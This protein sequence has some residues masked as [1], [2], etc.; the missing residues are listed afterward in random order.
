ML[1]LDEPTGRAPQRE[2][3]ERWWLVG[4]AAALLAVV[5]SLVVWAEEDPPSNVDEPTTTTPAVPPITDVDTDQADDSEGASG[6]AEIARDFLIAIS[7]HDAGAAWRSVAPNAA[8]SIATPFNPTEVVERGITLRDQLAWLEAWDWRWDDPS[9]SAEVH[10]VRGFVIS[11]DTTIQYDTTVTCTAEARYRLSDVDG[12]SQDAGLRLYAL[13]DRIVYGVETSLDDGQLIWTPS[14]SSFVDWAETN[15]AEESANIWTDD[16]P[17]L[18]QQA[19]SIVEELVREYVDTASSLVDASA[20]VTPP[21]AEFVGAVSAHDADTAAALVAD[22]AG[23][24]EVAPGS[25]LNDGTSAALS[26]QLRWLEA[27]GWTWEDVACTD[28]A[29]A[30]D[31]VFC[32]FD[33]RNRLTEATETE[34]PSWATFIVADGRIRSVTVDDDKDNYSG[35]AFMPY[36]SWVRS[37]YPD[38]WRVMW[39]HGGSITPVLNEESARLMDEHLTEYIASLQNGDLAV[40]RAYI[41]AYNERDIPTL[42]SL[43][44]DAERLFTELTDQSDPA[45]YF[46]WLDAFDWRW[47]DPGCHLEGDVVLCRMAETNKLIEFTGIEASSVIRFTITDGLVDDMAVTSVSP[48]Y[49]TEAFEPFVEWVAATYPDDAVVMWNF[50]GGCCGPNLTDAAIA[51]F[52]ARLDEWT[53]AD[54]PT[55]THQRFL[56]AQ[57]SGD[58]DTM[59]A[60]LAPDVGV[61]QLWAT[62]PDDL[63]PL[64]RLLAGLGWQWNSRTCSVGVP[65]TEG[66]VPVLRCVTSPTT[67]FDEITIRPAVVT[68]ESTAAGIASVSSGVMVEQ[69]SDDLAPFFDWVSTAYP[70]ESGQLLSDRGGATAPVLS[71]VAV[72]RLIEVADEYRARDGA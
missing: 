17:V 63:A 50:D 20:G 54:P 61:D 59:V 18:S 32:R 57:A 6:P 71:D 5:V 28:P 33:Q 19:A 25:V 2:H 15:H 41:E 53:S 45:A 44:T 40:A 4:A 30:R 46:A 69:I 24:I 47:T 8:I 14:W 60:T 72:A 29:V 64:A 23:P 48:Q 68:F 7:Q 34:I 66:A 27:F 21:I 16:G 39:T 36:Y 38:D 52:A 51:L 37:E 31:R 13:D 62:E 22:D 43:A 70:S 65:D 55:A 11:S 26:D 3:H 12:T 49:S 67:S 58:V 35:A 9:C 42:T 1:D 10:S 56:E